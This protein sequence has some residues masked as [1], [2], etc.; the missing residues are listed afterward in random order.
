MGGLIFR[1]FV[2]S[3]DCKFPSIS[4]VEKQTLFLGNPNEK[5]GNN[6]DENE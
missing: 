4:Y 2:S 1:Q 6:K 3:F 5:P